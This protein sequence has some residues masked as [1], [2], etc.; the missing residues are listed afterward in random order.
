MTIEDKLTAR[1]IRINRIKNAI[2]HI[3][4][5]DF[6]LVSNPDMLIFD[7]EYDKES[8][9]EIVLKGLTKKLEEIKNETL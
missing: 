5:N 1:T 3:E 4:Q 9:K 2:N 7:D 8:V 6:Y